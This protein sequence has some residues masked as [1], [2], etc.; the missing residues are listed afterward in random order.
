MTPDFVNA[1][2]ALFH[3][4][5]WP[6]TLIVV[7]LLYRKPISNLLENLRSL[8]LGTVVELEKAVIEEANAI[9]Q[10]SPE[11]AAKEVTL[12]Q[13]EAAERIGRVAARQ[14]LSTAREE[15]KALARN[16]EIV[17]AAMPSGNARTRRLDEL[18]VKMRTLGLACLPYL[19]ELATSSSPG[20]R[21]AAVTILQLKPDPAYYDWLA[22]RMKEE[23]NFISYH[24]AVA[25]LAAAR[26][27]GRNDR[28]GLE[29]AIRKAQEGLDEHT[30]R[31]RYLDRALD[32]LRK[33][34]DAS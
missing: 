16:Y 3:S 32:E 7:V 6:L 13:I 5:A 2:A 11:E 9:I 25:L 22:Q 31:R 23:S 27:A 4:I 8:K 1:L 29:I 19:R 21:L 34:L 20:E 18:V 30:G 10:T 12:E 15:M 33:P 28:P 17:R 14:D 26:H 24:A